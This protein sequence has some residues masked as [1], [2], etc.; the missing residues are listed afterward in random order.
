MRP[1]LVQSASPSVATGRWKVVLAFLAVYLIWGSTYYAIRVLVAEVPPLLAAGSR[2]F[3]AGLALY[4][5]ARAKGIPDPARTE[6]RNLSVLAG[7]MFLIAYS[8][9]FWAEKSIPSGVA[10]VL[11][12]TIPVWT[13]LL[14]IFVFRR[15]R[16]HTGLV[17]AIAGGL[18]GV[19][20]LTAAN[21]THRVNTLA[22]L[23]MI[24]AQLSW[25]FGTVLS[26]G[27][28]LPKSLL[29]SSA[30]QMLV[31][32][33]ML[34]LF[35]LFAGE[36]RTMPHFTVA[37][38]LALTYLIVAGSIVAFTAFTWLLTRLPA[39]QVSSYAYVNPV[40][41][42]LIGTVLG[43]E[44]LTGRDVFGSALVLASVLLL[45]RQKSAKV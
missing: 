12:A 36:L 7:L 31:G 9:L 21:M 22:C 10:S 41:A 18:C 44:A 38:T 24:G 16:L 2:F 11:V 26:K 42:L 43:G 39:T 34:L 25:S 40:I 28:V 29:M 17:L 13:A 19:G 35:S 4:L 8:A 3:I 45:I 37:S 23:A 6:W 15:G 14:E 27:M 33:L 32:G 30:G 5:W 1:N 20:I